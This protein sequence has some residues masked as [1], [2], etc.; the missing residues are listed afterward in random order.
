M[1]LAIS[2]I[3]IFPALPSYSGCWETFFLTNLQSDEPISTP[4][5]QSAAQ[6]PSLPVPGP[7]DSQLTD[8]IALDDGP[9]LER[10]SIWKKSGGAFNSNWATHTHM[11]IKLGLN[12]VH[13]CLSCARG[14]WQ[15]LGELK[16][17][18]TVGGWI[19]WL[20]S[21]PQIDMGER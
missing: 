4:N 11:C 6:F 15:S 8:C 20:F 16:Q 7:Q 3:L 19:Y 18:F 17:D 10:A 9:Y 2:C 21:K 14:Y 12:F 5:A 13:M 1:K